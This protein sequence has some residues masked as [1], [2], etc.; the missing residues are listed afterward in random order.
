MSEAWIPLLGMIGVSIFAILIAGF[1]GFDKRLAS[2]WVARARRLGR[3]TGPFS[4]AVSA[5]AMLCF[6]IL[7]GIGMVWTERLGH[8]LWAS[9][10]M[11]PQTL[12]YAPFMFITMPAQQGYWTWRGDLEVAGASKKQQ[13]QIAWWAGIPSLVGLVVA[14]G[15]WMPMFFP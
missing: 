8:W 9:C 2:W 3:L 14:L 13:R 1:V 4:F 5:A 11:L 12:V 6:S 7:L 15:F 10:F